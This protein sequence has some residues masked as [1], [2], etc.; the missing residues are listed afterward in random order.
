MCAMNRIVVREMMLA[1]HMLVADY[2]GNASDSHLLALG[3]DKAK[4]PTRD[5]WAETLTDQ[6][7][8]SLSER[9][10]FYLGWE[11]DGDLV[12]HSNLSPFAY[13]KTGMIHMH[14]HIWNQANRG[15][16]IAKACLGQSISMFFKILSLV[17]IICEPYAKNN[18]PNKT[19]QSLGFRSVKRYL[20]TP[21]PINLKQEVNRYE[22]YQHK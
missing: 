5:A 7:Q 9:H 14:M 4:L 13:G 8:Q 16:G 12:G 22:I 18:A 17:M 6:F 20:T 21:G 15:Q 1:E 19:L 10:M 3:V 11:Y 2:W